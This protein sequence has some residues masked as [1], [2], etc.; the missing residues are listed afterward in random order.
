M[1]VLG[2][3]PA[4]TV[5]FEDACVRESWAALLPAV[6]V[7]A[8][9]VLS[10]PLPA[11]LRQ[12]WDYIIEPFRTYITLP[13]AE[14][15]LSG[16][17]VASAA[18]VRHK[19]TRATPAWRTAVLSAC[20]LIPALAW[21]GLASFALASR[22]EDITTWTLIQPFLPAVA[23][24][25]AAILPVLNPRPTPAYELFALYVLQLIGGV[26]VL[27]GALFDARLGDA[28]HLSKAVLIGHIAD[29]VA[30][31]LLLLVS[32]STP[33]ALPSERVEKAEIGKSVSPED[34]TSLW[35]WISFAW[36]TPLVA[37]GTTATLNEQDIWALSPT[38]QSKAIFGKFAALQRKT[39]LR[40]LWAANSL[41]VLLDF[42][43]S[44]FLFLR[45]FSIRC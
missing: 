11:P 5:D 17:S 20:A 1:G 36:V 6:L 29:V 16:A 15:V 35:G 2:L 9:L 24:A 41:D 32:L 30:S 40:R 4:S 3:C 12:I 26:L 44:A 43:L 7:T 25:Y 21:A 8:Y 13:E 19:T 39:L 31:L 23:W 22:L 28:L 18:E 45:N 27:G 33:I 14:V 37:S 42:G 10:L 34:Y 38:L